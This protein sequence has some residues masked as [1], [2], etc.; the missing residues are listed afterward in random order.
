MHLT[1]QGKDSERVE[2]ALPKVDA[3]MG[4]I[5]VSRASVTDFAQE[6]AATL[7]FGKI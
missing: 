5:F 3:M 4:N 6:V 1:A 2:T 7:G